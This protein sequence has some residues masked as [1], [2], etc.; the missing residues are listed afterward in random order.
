M[1][2][3][4]FVGLFCFNRAVDCSA[5]TYCYFQADTDTFG[6]IGGLLFHILGI[7]MCPHV[8]KHVL[9]RYGHTL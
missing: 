7:A 3:Y 1:V 4:L 6:R 5:V 2:D 9:K 8:C